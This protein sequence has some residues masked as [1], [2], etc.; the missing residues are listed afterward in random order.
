MN[1]EEEAIVA[2]GMIGVDR[3]IPARINTDLE[4]LGYGI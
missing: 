4:M 1:S 2:A 3:E